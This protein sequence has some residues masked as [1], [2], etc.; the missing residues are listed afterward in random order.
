MHRQRFNMRVYVITFTGCNAGRTI[1][2]P[3]AGQLTESRFEL[4]PTGQRPH[5][6][7]RLRDA[8]AP[9]LDRLLKALGAAQPNIEMPTAANWPANSCPRWPYGRREPGPFGLNQ[10]MAGAASWVG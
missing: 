9:E 2:V 3:T 4:L 6:T 7:V 1:Y 8:D 5:F 10:L